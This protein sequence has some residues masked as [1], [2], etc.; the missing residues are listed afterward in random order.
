MQGLIWMNLKRLSWGDEMILL[1]PTPHRF[2]YAR[3]S[4]LTE[5]KN[6][7]GKKEIVPNSHNY[8]CLIV[9]SETS[10]RR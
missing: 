8:N 1:M 3:S 2:V 10:Q 7:L 9:S 4:L 5:G 6:S